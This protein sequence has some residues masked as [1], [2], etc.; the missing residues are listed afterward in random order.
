MFKYHSIVMNPQVQTDMS[1]DKAEPTP[2]NK[3]KAYLDSTQRDPGQAEADSISAQYKLL[4]K[5][6]MELAGGIY[7]NA[8]SLDQSKIPGATVV[9]TLQNLGP[10][11]QGTLQLRD[12]MYGMTAQ[13]PAGTAM[14]GSLKVS[15][16]NM[17][18]GVQPLMGIATDWYNFRLNVSDA[19]K[20]NVEK[21]LYAISAENAALATGKN[22][23]ESLSHNSK[24]KKTKG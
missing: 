15:T 7:N 4:E 6:L 14:L 16:D 13:T 9:A 18:G 21:A 11:S 22:V 20:T 23:L 3:V 12:A 8:T 24:S 5:Q 17:V 1:K 19:Q 2:V 10:Y